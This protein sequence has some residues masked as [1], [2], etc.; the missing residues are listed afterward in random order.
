MSVITLSSTAWSKAGVRQRGPARPSAAPPTAARAGR[1]RAPLGA[2]K[3][4]RSPRGDHARRAQVVAAAEA[5]PIAPR[6]RRRTGSSSRCRSASGLGV[7]DD[8]QPR[9]VGRPVE[10]GDVPRAAGQLRGVAA[11]RRHHEQV[12]IAAVDVAAGRRACSRARRATRATGVRRSCSRFSGGRGSSTTRVR[13]AT[14]PCRRTRCA[15]RRATRRAR[16]ALGQRAQLHAARRRRSVEHEEL[17]GGAELADEGEA[18]AV[19]RPLGRMIASRAAPS[20]RPAPGRAARRTT[21]RLRFCARLGVGPARADRRR[22]RRRGLSRT[23]SIQR[24][25]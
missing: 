13:V 8:D 23:W 14:A 21:M 22:A 15:C 3:A 11:R 18:A 1:R 20:P 25:R 16:R 7:A 5:G 17:V 24:K 2:M 12:V 19:G 9:A 4:M 6:G 10:T